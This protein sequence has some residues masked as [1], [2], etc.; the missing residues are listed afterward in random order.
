MAHK[1]QKRPECPNC[2]LR[3]REE[4]NYCARCGQENHT[5]K[6]PVRHYIVD[7][8]GGLFN[9]DTKLLRT[10]R[11]LFWPPGLATRNFNE[12]KRARYVPPLRL[13][14]FTSLLYFVAMAWL[15]GNGPDAAAD[16][17]KGLSLTAGNDSLDEALARMARDGK[18]T[19]AVLD[20]VISVGGDEPGF[21][22]RRLLR[23]AAEQHAGGAA[24]RSFTQQLRRNFSTA[25]FVLVPLFALLLKLICFRQKRY[26]TEHLVFALNY[27]SAFFILLLCASLFDAAFMA[28]FGARDWALRIAIISGLIALPWMMRTAYQRP[29][30][31]TVAKAVILLVVYVL[32]LG[33][34]IGLTAF[35]TSIIT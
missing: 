33:L 15:P 8:L 35:I 26:Y 16:E 23:T 1:R 6:I 12:N 11:D 31:R 7:L 24:S 17:K 3:L 29:W 18:L 5:H 28:A 21:I 20:S 32:L 13:Y 2:G 4:D 25:M 34:S 22:T 10:L 30:V 14:L 19:D 27:H 9:F